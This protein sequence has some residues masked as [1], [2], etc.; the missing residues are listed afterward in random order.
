MV[1]RATTT[2]K[3]R[4]SGVEEGKGAA[5]KIRFSATLLSP[6]LPASP[7]RAGA[8]GRPMARAVSWT[9]L[10]LP[11]EA[12]AKLPSRGQT[13]VEGTLNGLAF[14]A[15]LEPDGQGGHW[16][17]VDRK[18]REAAGAEAGD[19]VMLEIA[20]VAEGP[21]GAGAGG[22]LAGGAS[23]CFGV[24]AFV[25]GLVGWLLVM[26]KILQCNCCGAV[27]AAS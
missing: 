8:A 20:P 7:R 23:V 1:V 27:V 15:T 22:F 18:V 11:K 25:G 12:S 6:R 9:F 19:V 21:E 17:K 14:R 2:T 13:T 5:S 24:S 26:K 4:K 10:T 3:K 16:V